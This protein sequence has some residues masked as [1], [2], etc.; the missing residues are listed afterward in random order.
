MKYLKNKLIRIV[1]TLIIIVK[2]LIIQQLQKLEIMKRIVMRKIKQKLNHIFY[3]YVSVPIFNKSFVTETFRG[4]EERMG[5]KRKE[6][7]NEEDV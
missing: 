4:M 3:I 7:K 5:K 6:R 1:S 2:L